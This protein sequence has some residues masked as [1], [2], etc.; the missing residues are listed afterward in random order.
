MVV[1]LAFVEL[2]DCL[3]TFEVAADQDA[4]L[5]K[6][7]E[8]A[9]DRGQA[10]VR[11]FV[12]QHAEHVFGRHVALR[13]FLED[14][15]NLQAW[16]GGFEARVF[17]FVDI[18]HDRVFLSACDHVRG[19]GCAGNGNGPRAEGAGNVESLRDQPLQ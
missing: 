2:V 11:A 6:L 12:Q 16:Q 15:Q 4:G 5:F 8:H 1:V 19:G 3:G 7:H 13:A 10:D 9:V 14:L 18:R 17:E